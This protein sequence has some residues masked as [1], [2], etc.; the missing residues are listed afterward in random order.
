MDDKN[1]NHTPFD[2]DNEIYSRMREVENAVEI[3]KYKY[4]SHERDYTTFKA[5][6]TRVLWIVA[7]AIGSAVISTIVG[8]V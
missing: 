1:N 8:A 5:G 4:E 6:M 2:H 7:T 3:L